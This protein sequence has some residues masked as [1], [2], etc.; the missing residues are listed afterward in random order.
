[1]RFEVKADGTLGPGTVFLDVTSEPAPGIPDGLKLD[2]AGNLYGT[3]PGGVW[4]VSPQGK[5][6]GRIEAPELPANVAWGNDGRTLYLTAR[7]S[8]YRVT[9][10][11]R[12]PMPCC[13]AGAR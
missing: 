7:T 9:L 13:P 8:I 1:M 2:T 3:G 11:A 5:P 6:L 10:N 4:I 12:G